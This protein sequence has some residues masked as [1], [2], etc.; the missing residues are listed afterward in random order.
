MAHI[1]YAIESGHVIDVCLAE[2]DRKNGTEITVSGLR[3]RGPAQG[4]EDWP[5]LNLVGFGSVRAQ[6]APDLG[7]TGT[8]ASPVVA[9]IGAT[10]T[11][12]GLALV[13]L[14]GRRYRGGNRST[15]IGMGPS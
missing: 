15:L 9:A 2:V 11:I 12:S 13:V 5:G 10:L 6:V 4:S 7:A 1:D 14:R 3:V 8:S